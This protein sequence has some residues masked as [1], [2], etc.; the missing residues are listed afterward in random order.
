MWIRT[1]GI[2]NICFSL[3]LLTGL[4]CR[5]SVKPVTAVPQSMRKDVFTEVRGQQPPPEGIV[6]L[7]IKASIKTPTTEHYL[8][9]SRTPPGKEGYAFEL[10]IDGQEIIW[11]V[12]GK[13]E[14]TPV[15]GEHGRLPEGGEG[16]RYILDKTINLRP[17]PH[18]VVFGLPYDDYYTQVKVSLKEGEA[19]SLEFQPIYAMGR[20]AYRTFFYGVTRSE[21]F[22]DGVRIK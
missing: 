3:A 11:N 18:H 1:I 21:V 10:N 9:E 13:P 8:L 19:H 20:R 15:S 5:G 6:D 22:L 7:R 4:G 12:E 17:G 2:L 14:K 16:I